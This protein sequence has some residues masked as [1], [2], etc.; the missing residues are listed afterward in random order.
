V[1]TSLIYIYKKNNNPDQPR[2]VLLENYNAQ[3][4]PTAA[5]LKAMLL[6]LGF[7]KP[8]DNITALQ[9]FDKVDILTFSI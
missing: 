5:S 1:E 9:L 6:T 2:N 8:P 3:E 7:P 4:S